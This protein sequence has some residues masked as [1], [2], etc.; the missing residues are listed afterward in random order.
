MENSSLDNSMD[1]K[2]QSKPVPTECK[3]CGAPA[4]YSYFGAIVC[5]SCKIF[6]KRHAAIEQVN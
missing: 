5:Q 6:F 1:T 4:L 3:V 2:R